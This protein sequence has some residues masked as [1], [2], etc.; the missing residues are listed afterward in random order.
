MREF[1]KQQYAPPSTWQ[2]WT[3]SCTSNPACNTPQPPGLRLAQ[4]LMVV[5]SMCRRHELNNELVR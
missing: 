1:F 2:V 3:L 5:F 4:A